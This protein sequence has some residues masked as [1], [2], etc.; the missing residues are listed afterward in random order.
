MVKFATY[1]GH[2]KHIRPAIDS[3]SDEFILEN[4]AFSIRSF[5][6]KESFPDME[7]IHRW[8][9]TIHKLNPNAIISVNFD[10]LVHDRHI[11]IVYNL[12]R[13]IKEHNISKIRIQDLGLIP[14][15]AETAPQLQIVLGTETGNAN[16][17]SIRSFSHH[18][19][20][21]HLSNELPFTAI[22]QIQE[23]VQTPFDLQV[24]GP[25]L[26]QYSN[27]RFMTG[28][29]AQTSDTD[30]N[31]FEQPQIQQNAQAQE[32]PGRFF[33]FLDNTH[34]H[35]MFLYFDRCL[36]K[37]LPELIGL[38]LDTWIFDG[39]GESDRYAPSAIKLYRT[40][41][42]AYQKSPS[43]WF[44]QT[45]YDTLRSVANRPLRP[46]FFKVNRT[47]YMPR[48][49]PTTPD[50]LRHV[51]RIIDTVKGECV[52]VEVTHPFSATDTLIVITPNQKE[53]VLSGE[54]L[55]NLDGTPL[56]HANNHD[57]VML[58]WIKSAT[59]KSQVY[60]KLTNH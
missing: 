58:G 24:H 4:P 21:Q 15:L 39:R 41:Y 25:I 35:F 47:D 5:Q 44:N 7:H 49:H 55:S 60:I 38:N 59:A 26:I 8:A 22:K 23:K 36:Y 46:G 48:R 34:G 57:I 45:D 12:L 10:L 27:R 1:I 42:D 31:E 14:I 33:Q 30:S 18:V 19:H 28:Q 13:V 9:D 37:S 16:S 56:S 54:K 20:A 3:G 17:E 52:T 32:Y 53:L 29:N 50:G 51:G 11:G 6:E 40:A 2:T 43:S